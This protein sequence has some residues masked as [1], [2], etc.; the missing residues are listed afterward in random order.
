MGSEHGCRNEYRRTVVANQFADYKEGG[1][2]LG[3]VRSNHFLRGE[4]TGGAYSLSE[5]TFQPG[6][7]GTPLHVHHQEEELYYVI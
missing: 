1:S 3:G 5:L 4:Q 7:Q 6:S 2:H